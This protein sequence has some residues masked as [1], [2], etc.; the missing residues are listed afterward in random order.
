MASSGQVQ[1]RAVR[2]LAVEDE[3]LVRGLIVSVLELEGFEVVEA[4]DALTAVR[5]MAETPPD[6]VLLDIG[7][8]G[9]N[10]MDLLAHLRRD[11]DVP[12]IIL[13][14]AGSEEQRIAGLKEGADDYVVK[15]FSSGELVARIESILRRTQRHDAQ[16][17]TP[18]QAQAVPPVDDVKRFDRLTID[19]RCREVHVDGE[20]VELT[21]REFDLLDYVAG[22]P[23]QVFSR[24][25]LL[26]QVW[27]S[28]SEWQ[29]PATVTEHVRR[30]RRKIEADPDQPRWV[31]TVRGVGYRFDP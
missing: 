6:L 28:S 5:A 21:A 3:P 15:P 4:A 30:V 25:Q 8:P 18:I 31:M 9:T 27:G 24:E 29:D 14:G 7:L 22:S 13:T 26:R 1:Q 16:E 19:R 23:R 12:V 17:A 2:I 20:V 10:G 11:G